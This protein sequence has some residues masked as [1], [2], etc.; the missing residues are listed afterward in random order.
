MATALANRGHHVEVATTNLAGTGRIPTSLGQETAVFGKAT[1]RIFPVGRPVS[2]RV[3]KAM[4]EFLNTSVSWF[5]IVHIHSL[6]LYHT[7]AA[8]SA[9]GRLRVPYLIRPHGALDPYHWNHHRLRKRLHWWAIE[10]RLITRSAGLHFVSDYEA[11]RAAAACPGVTGWIVPLGVDTGEL[12]VLAAGARR[13]PFFEPLRIVFLSRLAQKKNPR[14]VIDAVSKLVAAGYPAELLCAGPEEDFTA[15]HLAQ[16]AARAG[17][18][19]RVTYLGPI[20]LEDRARLLGASHVLV[21]PSEDENFGLVVVEA[22]SLGTPVLI[23][24]GVA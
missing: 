6:H 7:V 18:L 23:S 11:R 22:L 5:D 2:Y 16:W 17:V 13:P 14:L 24:S 3:S 4:G 20:S 19:D 21:L 15:A 8:A 10:K 9:C 12:S 1:F